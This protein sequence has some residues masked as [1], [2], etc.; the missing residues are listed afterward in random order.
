M[1]SVP[2]YSIDLPGVTIT[3]KYVNMADISGR[4][5]IRAKV[6]GLKGNTFDRDIG[7]DAK[8][9]EP[10]ARTMP[11]RSTPSE[12]ITQPT[13]EMTATP[14]ERDFVALVE[15][16]FFAYRDFTG[17]PDAILAEYKLGRAHHR[18]LHFVNRH[19]GL[20]VAD[21]LDLLKVTKQSLSRVLKTLVDQ[22]W[23]EQVS[24]ID[25]R[26]GSRTDHDQVV[27]AAG[28]RVYPLG[29]IHVGSESLVVNVVRLQ[30]N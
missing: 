29:R 6:T 21:L 14:C 15:L 3:V 26:R 19:P 8:A 13:A 23:V 4:P 12:T 11:S 28:C 30:L 9:V 17:E 24:G 25:D 1:G 22:G 5:V 16:F 18:V 2:S 10:D 7:T 20:R 27:W